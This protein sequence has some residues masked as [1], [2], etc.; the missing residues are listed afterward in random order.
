[1][2]LHNSLIWRSRLSVAMKST[3]GSAS[4]NGTRSALVCVLSELATEEGFLPTVLPDVRLMHSKGKYPPS[5]VVYEPSIVI[6]AQGYKR[7]RLGDSTFV[8]D[9]RNY[10]V[11]SVPLPFECETVGT[12]TKPMLGLAIRVSPIAVAEILLE[13]DTPWPPASF[14]P[15]AIDASPLTSELADASLR[16][17]KCLQSSVESRVLGPAIIREIIY[18][19]LCDKHGD[20]LRALAT[21]RSNFSQVARSLRRIH[22]D[23]HQHLDVTSLAREASMSVSMFHANFKA[24]TSKSPLHYLQTIRLH[25]AQA[26]IGGGIPVAE[27]A[28]KVGYE[29]PSQF[30]R[31]FKRL[32]GRTPNEIANRSRSS[33]FAF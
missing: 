22:A 19:V 18:R 13:W 3:S 11:L 16:L 27:A 9:S 23:Y 31:E 10:L 5:P 15:R 17:A 7:A 1:M 30:S 21:P 20:A 32:F 12:S 26:L 4:A 25:K 6:I 2:I 33:L 14:L 29:S 8:Y 24:V 28:R